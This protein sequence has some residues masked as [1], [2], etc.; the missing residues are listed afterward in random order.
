MEGW[1]L[2]VA[3]GGQVQATALAKSNSRL[4]WR[5]AA[6]ATGRIGAFLHA[7][8]GAEAAEAVRLHGSG[9][10]GSAACKGR[11]FACMGDGDG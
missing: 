1:L 11:R 7:A 8:T 10:S 2:S 9:E 3:A 6:N 4:Y 5:Q